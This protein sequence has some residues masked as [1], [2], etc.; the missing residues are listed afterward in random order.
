MKTDL[1]M[2]DQKIE[3]SALHDRLHVGVDQQHCRDLWTFWAFIFEQTVIFEPAW[4]FDQN[5][6]FESC[7]SKSFRLSD[8]L[9]AFQSSPSLRST[10]VSVDA[11][12]PKKNL[13][14][15]AGSLQS[16]I[17]KMCKDDDSAAA[18]M[19][20]DYL[21]QKGNVQDIEDRGDGSQDQ[22]EA[23]FTKTQRIL[24]G[25][26]AP[27]LEADPSLSSSA[28][29]VPP[30]FQESADGSGN[31]PTFSS[32][33]SIQAGAGQHQA[34][35]GLDGPDRTSIWDKW[36]KQCHAKDDFK[37][38]GTEGTLS[39]QGTNSN[40][41]SSNAATKE[42]GRT[43]ADIRCGGRAPG[44]SWSSATTTSHGSRWRWPSQMQPI[45]PPTVGKSQ[46]GG[47]HGS[48]LS[49]RVFL[50]M[51]CCL[52]AA[53]IAAVGT[54]DLVAWH[55]ECIDEVK[56]EPVSLSNTAD[57]MTC[58]VYGKELA[59]HFAYATTDLN[60]DHK[61]LTKEDKKFVLNNFK[62]LNNTI[63]EVYSPERV[64]GKAEEHGF[65]AG[66]ALDLTTGWDFAKENHR[67]SALRLIRELQPALVI[68]SPPCTEF[69]K[70][71]FLPNF[72]RNPDQVRREEEEALQHLRFAV[73]IARIQLR[74]GRGFLFEHPRG[75]T[76]WAHEELDQLRNEPGV[77]CAGVAGCSFPPKRLSSKRVSDIN[78]INGKHQILE[79]DWR[80]AEAPRFAFSQ[81]WTG[82]TTFHLHDPIVLPPDW[83]AV[84]NY[85]TQ[86]AAHPI[87]AYLMEETALQ[88]AWHA[89][90]PTHKIL[91][92]GDFASSSSASTSSSSAAAGGGGRARQAVRALQDGDM[93][94]QET[95]QDRVQQALRELHLP[96]PPTDNILHPELR[97][98]LFRVH[99][100]WDILHFK[101]LF[102][103][104]DM[105]E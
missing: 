55:N 63:V 21:Q 8:E 97:R 81:L 47:R 67:Q 9:D 36:I 72:K 78:F 74:A 69:S 76:S 71:R 4:H 10:H 86:A 70:L 16:S 12:A 28:T 73:A 65:Q 29:E 53:T 38:N 91:G 99:L 14:A 87:H 102:E 50:C 30:G 98:E 103:L 83:K 100:N 77:F 48:S 19:V 96:Q 39:V 85:I 33:T 22:G 1:E 57:K 80:S 95:S 58:Y 18:D 25:I 89:S 34:E 82:T 75:A 61:Q 23:E 105:L 26:G 79:D 44:S 104:Y 59:K 68:L 15:A 41:P 84:A 17:Y 31:L 13:T 35:G 5:Y 32:G 27:L 42:D 37:A 101:F 66:G 46:L 94:E 93:D 40:G 2:M 7:S 54:P 64:T 3:K 51:N 56:T 92:G 62:K 24:Q 6:D 49:S 43:S 11:M 20:L 88:V 90:F 45:Q 52:S 60:G